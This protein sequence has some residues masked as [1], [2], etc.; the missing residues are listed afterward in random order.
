MRYLKE[1]RALIILALLMLLSFMYIDRPIILWVKEMHNGSSA[2]YP[3]LALSGS[4]I[5]FCADGAV[6]ITASF[7]LYLTGR[8]WRQEL[9]NAGKSLFLALV[10]SGIFV[11]AVK[12]L[13]GRARPGVTDMTEFIGPNIQKGFESFPSGH[14]ALAF[15]FAFVSSFYFPKYKAF[16]YAFA[17]L[18]A[19]ERV[20]ELAHFP[21]DV[22][23]G[24]IAGTLASKII[25]SKITTAKER[26]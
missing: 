9:F 17:V 3:L 1:N 20:G 2:I 19:V 13:A 10:S 16:F 12:R 5:K 18:V 8:F 21:S 6:I 26:A 24:M 25:L 23:A 7:L 11:Q 4:I 22:L 15:A 14:T